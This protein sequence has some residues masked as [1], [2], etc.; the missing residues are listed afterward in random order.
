[1]EIDPG[2]KKL[3]ENSRTFGEVV[4][5]MTKPYVEAS[6]RLGKALGENLAPPKVK[7][8][9]KIGVLFARRAEALAPKRAIIVQIAGLA[10]AVAKLPAECQQPVLEAV[11]KQAARPKKGTRREVDQADISD[12]IKTLSGMIGDKTLASLATKEVAMILNGIVSG[13]TTVTTAMVSQNTLY[14]KLRAK[15]DAPRPKNPGGKRLTIDRVNRALGVIWDDDRE[16]MLG[17]TLE[18][19]AK[20]IG[21]KI[22]TMPSIPTIRKTKTY[23]EILRAREQAKRM[24]RK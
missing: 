8:L 22:G 11:R 20:R 15:G 21:H 3:V 14:W 18:G 16:A 24:K 7:L 17:A 23:Q 10:S 1:M 6:T 13:E 5:R 12:G 9:E 4:E 2:T 19:I